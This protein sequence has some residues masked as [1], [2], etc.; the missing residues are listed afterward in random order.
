MSMQ[1]PAEITFNGLSVSEYNEDYI[2][3]R[4]QRLEQFTDDIIACRV[5][6]ER[7]HAHRQ[8]GNP[9]RVRVELTLPKRKELVVDKERN[10]EPHVELSTVIRSA[11]DTLERQ[12]NKATE[13]R[14]GHV[15]VPVA[16]GESTAMVSK[17][18]REDGYGFIRTENGQEYYVHE[19]SVLNNG[20]ERMEIGTEVRF[21]PEMGEDG[22]QASTVQ[23][24]A[25]PGVRATAQ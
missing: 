23:I 7:P 16:D 10:V 3:E 24:I 19:N 17:L 2:R 11:F 4:I 8:T 18:F 5:A 25:K 1:V 20:F 14:R 15:K 12:L 9:F 22:P 13:R 6:V 21:M